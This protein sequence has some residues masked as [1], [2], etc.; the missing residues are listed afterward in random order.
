MDLPQYTAT[1]LATAMRNNPSSCLNGWDMLLA[2]PLAA[3][4]TAVSDISV[5]ALPHHIMIDTTTNDPLHGPTPISLKVYITP[6]SMA[7]TDTGD[8]G[9]ITLRFNLAGGLPLDIN[10]NGYFLTCTAPLS[11]VTASLTGTDPISQVCVFQHDVATWRLALALP[12]PMVTVADLQGNTLPLSDPRLG[13]EVPIVIKYIQ[14]VG[15]Q[16]SLIDLRWN[17]P[18][19]ALRPTQ[20]AFSMVPGQGDQKAVVLMWL[21]LDGVSDRTVALDPGVRNQFMAGPNSVPTYPIPTDADPSAGGT[22]FI[23][24]K[25]AYDLLIQPQLR[26]YDYTLHLEP[27]QGLSGMTVSMFTATDHGHGNTTY[28]NTGTVT[29]DGD[30]LTDFKILDPDGGSLPH[31]LTPTSASL[32]PSDLVVPTS[33]LASTKTLFTVNAVNGLYIPHD[34]M[35]VGVV[36]APTQASTGA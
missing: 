29:L 6:S 32:N 28:S 5:N 17:A 27:T 25:A 30:S 21:E 18:P 11:A 23:S 7:F 31:H 33:L 15:L 22:V 14:T 4:N 20:V 13:S 19:S 36:P 9:S 26:S 3:L 16:M 35:F 1:D 10:A 12:N 2:Y 34:F 8:G 24:R